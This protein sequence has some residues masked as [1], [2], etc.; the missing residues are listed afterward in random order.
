MAG[1]KSSVAAGAQGLADAAADGF[2]KRNAALEMRYGVTQAADVND[3]LVA[4]RAAQRT[5]RQ[6]ELALIADRRIDSLGG[7]TYYDY[8]TST[9]D[10]QAKLQRAARQLRRKTAVTTRKASR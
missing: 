7:I 5:E 8:S 3:R 4:I 2:A 9:E 10:K 1:M 6:A